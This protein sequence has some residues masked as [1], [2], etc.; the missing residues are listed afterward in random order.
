MSSS[1]SNNIISLMD[2]TKEQ[3]IK[4]TWEISSKSSKTKILLEILPSILGL[5]K[6]LHSIKKQL[7]LVNSFR[8]FKV[9]NET[10]Y[11]FLKEYAYDEWIVFQKNLYFVNKTSKIKQARKEFANYEDQFTSL[12][13]SGKIN[14]NT[15]LDLTLNDYIFFIEEYMDSEFY[16]KRKNVTCGGK[17]KVL[18]YKLDNPTVNKDGSI[19]KYTTVSNPA[20]KL[21]DFEKSETKA[22]DE[23]KEIDT[24]NF[25][26][27][28]VFKSLKDRES[29]KVEFGFGMYKGSKYPIEQFE[30]I[31]Y[32]DKPKTFEILK[33]KRTF[34]KELVNNKEF[35]YAKYETAGTEIDEEFIYFFD[36]ELI[37]YANPNTYGLVDGLLFI[38]DTKY[39]IDGNNGYK[40]FRYHQGKFYYLHDLLTKG[41]IPNLNNAFNT[42]EETHSTEKFAEFK[43][44]LQVYL[45][46]KRNN[47]N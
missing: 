13:F 20:S 22:E 17:K 9:S 23:V 16:E 34:P 19:P 8:N 31:K 4:S 41:W 46:S 15:A 5:M 1:I 10:Y 38:V 6:D 25:K 32:E 36:E 45:N 47:K 18:S 35:M 42:Y 27:F 7:I 3:E 21:E 37:Q 24:T 11:K 28:K 40:A 14:G 30:N 12:S 2:S 33:D 39:S 26:D 29:I 43:K 44:G